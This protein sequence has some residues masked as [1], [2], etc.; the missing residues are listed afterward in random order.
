M[1]SND[2]AQL[3]DAPLHTTV[4]VLVRSNI[5]SGRLCPG[6]PLTEYGLAQELSLSRV[7]VGRA[8]QRLSDDGLLVRDGARGYVV[9]GAPRLSGRG[10]LELEIPDDVLSLVRGRSEWQKHWDRVQGDL[11]ACMPFGRFKI[12]ETTMATHYGVSRTVTRDLLARLETLGLVER[13]ARSQCF[14]RHLTSDLMAELYEVRRLL[15]P[16]ALVLAAPFH[17][18]DDLE[19]VR[20]SL[21][22]AETNYPSLAPEVLTRFE[23]DLHIDAIGVCPNRSLISLLQQAQTLIL[24]TN[25]LIPLYLGMPSDEPFFS[26]HRLVFELL[27]SG[28]PEAAGLALEAHLKSA[29]RKQQHRLVELQAHSPLV[30][31]YLVP[32]VTKG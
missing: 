28:A 27:L 9:E 26:E 7:P 11:V 21:S 1:H 29:E 23:Q 19:R 14:L 18:R 13:E 16:T 20:A 25:A 24:S 32:I 5:A 8:L 22:D 15:E 12:I 10:R 30:P 2:T 31:P 3:Q 4:Y 17:T 6:T